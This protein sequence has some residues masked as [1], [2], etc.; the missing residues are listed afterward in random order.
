MPTRFGFNSLRNSRG[1][2]LFAV[3][4]VLA[5]AAIIVLSGF[6]LGTSEIHA[7]RTERTL[8]RLKRIEDAMIQ[9]VAVNG[10]L[11]CPANVALDTGIENPF[12]LNPQNGPATCAT[13]VGTVPWHTLGISQDFA[14]DAWAQ[15]IS[16]RVFHGPTGLTQTGGA[17]MTDCDLYDTGL[18]LSLPANG[19]CETTQHDN[20]AEQFLFNKG[21][22][23]DN[24]GNTTSGVAFVLISHGPTGNGAYL[25]GG[26]QKPLPNAA[27]VPEWA[28]AANDT[29]NPAQR[30]FYARDFS[31]SSVSPAD[32][33]HFDDL[34]RF[35]RIDELIRNAARGPRNW[36]DS[37]D[38]VGFDE[39]TTA[40]MTTPGT[41][42]FLATGNEALAQVFV[43]GSSPDIV[44]LGGN[45]QF[46]ACLWWPDPLQIYF[47]LTSTAKSFRMAVDFSFP[48]ATVTSAAGLVV[49]FISGKSPPDINTCGTNSSLPADA[50]AV[51]GD[52]GWGGGTYTTN[53]RFGVEIDINA[54]TAA[55]YT[56]PAN[57]HIAIDSFNT[58]HAGTVGPV[59]PGPDCT[60]AWLR[61]G[62]TNYHRLRIELEPRSVACGGHITGA[63]RLR[64]WI[65][66]N[67]VCAANPVECMAMRLQ[68]PYP[69]FGLPLGTVFVESC[70]APP[71]SGDVEAY[72]SINFGF[73]SAKAADTGYTVLNLKQLQSGVY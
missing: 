60:T 55:P 50:E 25:P 48:D 62:T 63:P 45:S 24:K 64:F 57:N 21:L 72:D 49:G 53:D 44:T 23:F 35:I 65:M 34:T 38:E 4:T 19:L 32:A 3:V 6:I 36:T 17:S 31:D 5:L 10:R 37:A 29:S 58:Y 12:N 14:L 67:S 52:L 54:Q 15:K 66:P 1:A 13:L 51:L 16:Y 33:N 18:S 28:N 68:D 22:T 42:H 7:G 39:T 8:D 27:N 41:G 2:A 56:D 46:S 30:T 9:F 47:P 71:P 61:D 40:N 11:P 43:R 70:L 59:C 20:T 73:T 69:T 26:N